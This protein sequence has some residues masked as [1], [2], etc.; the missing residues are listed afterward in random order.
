LAEALA[1]DPTVKCR[2]TPQ[3]LTI[4]IGLARWIP[5]YTYRGL[6]EIFPDDKYGVR[7]ASRALR[8]SAQT[9]A[10]KAWRAFREDL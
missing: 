2:Q 10:V 6:K 1:R 7:D 4:T 9:Y 5:E 3:I 8:I